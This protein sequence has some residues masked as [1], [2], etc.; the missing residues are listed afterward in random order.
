MRYTIQAFWQG[1]GAPTGRSF[2]KTAAQMTGSTNRSLK[3]LSSSRLQELDGW[4]PRRNWVRDS[5][6]VMLTRRLKADADA[7]DKVENEEVDDDDEQALTSTGT[8]AA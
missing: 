8:S 3:R 7:R 4:L 6:H 2:P 5:G 1:V